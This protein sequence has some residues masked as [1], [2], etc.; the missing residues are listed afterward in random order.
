M[1][2]QKNRDI[3]TVGSTTARV[4]K[5]QSSTDNKGT[6]T[7]VSN[8]SVQIHSTIV[9]RLAG[10]T[11]S[12]PVWRADVNA[13]YLG[14]LL[15]DMS[16]R[17][18]VSQAFMSLEIANIIPKLIAL[19]TVTENDKVIQTFRTMSEVRHTVSN[20]EA[21]MA[22]TEILNSY[23]MRV[24]L[25]PTNSGGYSS[26]IQY[27]N[28]PVTVAALAHNVLG[29]E[30]FKAVSSLKTVSLAS[31]RYTPDVLGNEIALSMEQV[32]RVLTDSH[33]MNSLF[34]D[35]VKGVRARIDPALTGLNGAV[36]LTWRDSAVVTEASHNFV[37]VQAALQLPRGTSITPTNADYRLDQYGGAA[38]AAL[39]SSSRYAFV[40]LQDVK[41]TRG[42]RRVRDRYG[43]VRSAV[44]W[45]SATPDAVAQVVHVNEDARLGSSALRVSHE[46]GQLGSALKSVYD[47]VNGLGTD[48]A[49]NAL[50]KGLRYHVDSDI[51]SESSEYSGRSFHY[52][53]V[54]DA[55][56]VSST[57]LACLLSHRV[58]VIANDTDKAAD[59][60]TTASRFAYA[61]N[62]EEKRLPLHSGTIYG[63]TL[64]TQSSSDVF[65]AT[66]DF[67]PQSTLSKVPQVIP[68]S[69]LNTS[70]IGL[71][72][73]TRFMKVSTRV[74]YEVT[75]NGVKLAGRLTAS[76]LDMFATNDMVSIV[77]P[78]FNED[79][80]ACVNAIHTELAELTK[81]V[82]A[83]PTVWDPVKVH[84]VDLLAAT[85]LSYSQCL[86]L[87][88]R[89]SVME[90]IE[91][92]AIRHL[93][94]DEAR[95]L[96]GRLESE[97]VKAVSAVIA[98]YTFQR[99]Q[100]LDSANDF[101]A[102]VTDADIMAAVSRSVA[103]EENA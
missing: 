101:L 12:E 97:A 87:R 102:I 34:E 36:S 19:R 57:E 48:V 84:M 74:S 7:D 43:I 55:A 39:K 76:D 75:I 26:L 9:D 63:G 103:N 62:T 33:E 53:S 64:Y 1:A 40:T 82:G 71:D 15:S 95:T 51:E 46:R 93:P 60:T 37:F 99:M 14:R 27:V 41:R 10:V 45:D 89:K 25:T 22:L 79:V 17:N 98:M 65:L 30:V 100:G 77:K 5:I 72:P 78:Q 18:R 91:L 80:F 49:I 83:D 13:S 28:G 23:L 50:T 85:M 6:P 24:G 58:F 3:I 20:I 73:S 94:S 54:G 42:L 68:A 56:Y 31:G 86:S 92:A 16:V 81:N 44:L 88:Y 96:M 32:G 38:W 70:Y 47:K 21:S 69:G 11:A 90:L 66:A 8:I 52:F 59:A 2:T 67:E 61:V 29:T 4:I 35:I